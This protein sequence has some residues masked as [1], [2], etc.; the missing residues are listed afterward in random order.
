MKL[1]EI[2]LTHFP[3]HIYWQDK[4]NIFLGCNER[5]AKTAGLSSRHDL[6]GRTVGEFQT[7]ENTDKILNINNKVMCTGIPQVIEEAGFRADKTE[8][9]YVSCKMPLRDSLGNIIGLLGISFDITQRK[10]LAISLKKAF[11]EIKIAIQKNSLGTENLMAPCETL[12]YF[13]NEILDVVNEF[14]SSPSTKNKKFQDEQITL[15]PLQ[16]PIIDLNLGA[17]IMDSNKKIAQHMIT[18]MLKN[19]LPETKAFA[20]A[21]KAKNWQTLQELAHKLRGGAL[22]CGTPRLQEA[23]SRLENYLHSGQTIFIEPLYKQM[24]TELESVKNEH[25][26]CA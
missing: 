21:Y 20:V 8:G 19:S 4:N 15:S 26:S 16:G 25:K 1:D 11:K 12:A 7:K 24:L 13:H 9:L 3:G 5:Q 17:K 14:S 18:F 22:Y 23:C 10:K 2:L 6:V